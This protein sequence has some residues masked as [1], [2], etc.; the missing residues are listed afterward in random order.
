MITQKKNLITIQNLKELKAIYIDYL[1]FILAY[2]SD[3]K[4]TDENVDIRGI[5]TLLLIL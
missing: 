5:L 1:K 4:I 3:T 2:T